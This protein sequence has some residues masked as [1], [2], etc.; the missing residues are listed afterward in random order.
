MKKTNTGAMKRL[1][2]GLMSIVLIVLLIPFSAIA[3]A[4]DAIAKKVADPSTMHT[5][6][7]YFGSDVL[8]TANAGGV[9][10]DKSVFTDASEFP[11]SIALKDDKN[12]LVSLS[13]IAANKTIVGYS[14]IPTDTMLVLDLSGSMANS[15]SVDDMVSAANSAIKELYKVNNHNRVGVVLY[16]GN[17][18]FGVSR[19]NTANVILPL[20]RY[21]SSNRNGNFLSY[22]PSAHRRADW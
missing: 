8:N 11:S 10:I 3:I 2:A 18:D 7:N 13:A 4:P 5:W 1:T 16:S 6:K 17:S 12:F 21:T 19:T 9:W 15:G 22:I 20:D 14:N